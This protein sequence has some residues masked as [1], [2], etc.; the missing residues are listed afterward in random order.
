M[1]TLSPL[2]TILVTCLPAGTSIICIIT[3]TWTIIKNLCKLKENEEIKLERDA[4]M[5]TNKKMMSE[6]RTMKKQIAM[7]IEKSS[8]V[9]YNDLS[10]VQ[11]DKTLQI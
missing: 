9:V 4:L 1:F 3:A 6:I 8:K 10:E 7:L 11:N 2:E 5:D